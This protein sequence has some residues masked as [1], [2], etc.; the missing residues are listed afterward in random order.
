M[1][2]NIMMIENVSKDKA[3]EVYNEAKKTVTDCNKS[4][5]A[6][7]GNANNLDTGWSVTKIKF[8]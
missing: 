8:D 3:Y 7:S 2:N 4:T 5:I 1:N 6:I